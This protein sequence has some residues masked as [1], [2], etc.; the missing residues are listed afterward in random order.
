MEPRALCTLSNHSTHWAASLA[1]SPSQ[2]CWDHEICATS[3][4]LED[5]MSWFVWLLM[6]SSSFWL[7]IKAYVDRVKSTCSWLAQMH[8]HPEIKAMTWVTSNDC[9]ILHMLTSSLQLGTHAVKESLLEG[10]AWWCTPLRYLYFLKISFLVYMGVFPVWVCAWYACGVL[11]G[12]WWHQ[13]PRSQLLMIVWATIGYSET[14]PVPF[15][16]KPVLLPRKPLLQPS[17]M[18]V[19]PHRDRR[20]TFYESQACISQPRASTRRM[21]VTTSKLFSSK[22]S[23]SCV[24]SPGLQISKRIL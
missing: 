8:L 18:P 5:T 10:L 9:S 16:G 11:R 4:W 23:A 20:L 6:L 2:L 3:T 7:L 13:V 14:N 1:P 15:E 12:Q 19:S 22:E 21:H 17:S 24:S